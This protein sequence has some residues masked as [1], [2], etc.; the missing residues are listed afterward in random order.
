M[1]T[2]DKIITIIFL[3][4]LGFIAGLWYQAI[5]KQVQTGEQFMN[6]N[7]LCRK[8]QE[9]QEPLPIV[10]EHAVPC[11]QGCCPVCWY[12]YAKHVPAC[13]KLSEVKP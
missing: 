8:C 3:L 13:R 11:P 9:A 6:V 4:L 12:R 7:D 1:K 5:Q 2:V 10:P